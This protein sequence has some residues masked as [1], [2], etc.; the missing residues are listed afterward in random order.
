MT[1]ATVKEYFSSIAEL[2]I[3]LVELPL[4]VTQ[5]GISWM[6]LQLS[7]LNTRLLY[8]KWLPPIQPSPQNNDTGQ[9]SDDPGGDLTIDDALA[10]LKGYPALWVERFRM[11]F[12]DSELGRRARVN[13]GYGRL[14]AVLK[15]TKQENLQRIENIFRVMTPD[16]LQK[17][18]QSFK[19]HINAV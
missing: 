13:S 15:P 1:K 19:R 11:V 17:S 18:L 7:K 6:E 9:A 14:Y 2:L 16:E 8:G 4:V 12:E 5:L 3:V 10:Y